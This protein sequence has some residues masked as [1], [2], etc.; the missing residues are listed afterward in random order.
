[1][2]PL[3][4]FVPNLINLVIRWV[5]IHR[6]IAPVK[7]GEFGWQA[8]L[9]PLGPSL[10]IGGVATLWRL[11]VFPPFV[12]GLE[13]LVGFMAATLIAGMV[14]ILFAFVGCLMFMFFPLYTAFGGW[15]S[16]SLGIFGEAVKISGP[17]R[18]LF[19]PIDKLSRWLGLR[20]PLHD[21]FPIAYEQAHRE[22]VELMMERHI[23]DHLVRIQRE[24]GDIN[25]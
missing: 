2:I 5:Y 20:S 24:R 6:H 9:A 16:N 21:R 7:F 10:I 18:F 25:L 22:A 17:S 11:L 13:P 23:K 14:S 4:H 8:F 15:D 1:V 3:Q 19:M 12:A